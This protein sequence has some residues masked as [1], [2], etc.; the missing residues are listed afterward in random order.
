MIPVV[1]LVTLFALI[2]VAGA[3][4]EADPGDALGHGSTVYVLAGEP[5]EGQVYPPPAEF[6]NGAPA[7]ATMTISYTGAW[8]TAA[9]TALEYA[10][11]IWATQLSSPVTIAV[12]AEWTST[13][14]PGTLGGAGPTQY[15]AN[16]TG[17]TIANT[18]FPVA[19]A[20]KLAGSDLHPGPEITA[21]FSSTVTNWY[22][23]TAGFPAANQYDFVT[24]ALHELGHGLGFGGSMR[25]GSEC[26][27]GNWGCWGWGTSHPAVYDR[28]TED[29]P[30]GLLINLPN[31]SATLGSALTSGNIYFDGP[32]A[33]TGNGG[34]RVPL[35][36][37]NPWK[38]G[39]SYNHVSETF[40]GT[41]NA[42]MTYS[43]GQGE[44]QHNPGTV[45]R[46]MFL[47]MSWSLEGPPT[48]TKT[49]TRTPTKTA[50]PTVTPT[51]TNTPTPTKTATPSP[52]PTLITMTPAT[53]SF[54]PLIANQPTPLPTPGWVDIA[55]QTF[56]G[57][58][59]GAWTL[60]DNTGGAFSFG[61]RGCQPFQGAFSGWAVGG[62]SSGTSLECAANYPNQ[63]TTWMVFGPFSLAGDTAAE[64]TL[65]AWYQTESYPDPDADQDQVRWCASP[66]GSTFYCYQVSGS[67]GGWV[68]LAMDLANVPV[69]GSMLGDDSVWIGVQFES[70]LNINLPVGL[71][72]DNVRVRRCVLN[73]AQAAP[74]LVPDN[75]EPITIE[76][77]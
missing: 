7:A 56:E 58:F 70:D 47:D 31:N 13:L 43:I 17:N 2:I 19:L 53:P 28:F 62:G 67:S 4:G 52:S 25:Y 68:D 16:F 38:P 15:F 61:K 71:Y 26:G 59:P 33:R 49:P 6:L 55:N 1:L 23:G 39:S 50:T 77:D 73:C 74:V 35:Y 75:W 44:V 18:W 42:L 40:N 69:F 41:A 34:L 24:V 37:P 51:K 20:N 63:V 27:G 54:L 8:P 22:F 32:N 36:A 10:A 29:G 76:F 9:K 45:M 14:P 72:V 66:D 57:D 3:T 65:K 21:S 30:G 5:V 12:S 48:P 11:A 60:V 64:L 46:G